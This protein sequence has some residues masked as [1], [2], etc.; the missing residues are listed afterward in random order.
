MERGRGRI[1]R[2]LLEQWGLVVTAAV[3]VLAYS[4]LVRLDLHFG[5]LRADI[6][7][8]TIGWY[9]LAFAA[10]LGAVIWTEKRPVSMRSVWTAAILFRLLLLFTS[11]SLSDDVYRYLWDGHIANQGVSPYA[12]AIN[13][14]ELDA[15]AI[16]LQE[17]ANN[18]EMASPYLPAAQWVFAG[19]TAV[20]PP[21][22]FILQL[23]M[24]VFDLIS[25][26]LIVR[27]LALAALPAHRALLYLWNPLVILETAHGAHI[28]A[29]MILLTLAAVKFTIDDRQFVPKISNLGMRI[30]GPLFMA[31]A[32]LTKVLPILLLPVLA[33]QWSWRQ[34]LA[35]VGFSI[36]IV[37]PAAWQ[38][39]WG[40][41]GEL[42]GTGLFG[43]LRI[44]AVQWNFNSGL[45]A[46]LEN[47][48]AGRGLGD[49]TSTAKWI[50]LALL[51][52]ILLGVWG[53]ARAPHSPRKTL[54]LAAI[55]FIA[56]LLL[57]PTVHPWYALIVLVL[58]PF[59][60]PGADEPRR[61]WLAVIPWL[62]LSGALVFSY[63]TYIDPLDFHEL[64]WVRGL[65]WGPTLAL[66]LVLLVIEVIQLISIRRRHDL[67]LLAWLQHILSDL[68]DRI[69]GR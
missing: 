56:Y 39:G 48:L 45:F 13:S 10:Y 31:L 52:I 41:T 12:Y 49:P 51:L 8:Q 23:S 28:D 44:Y 27:L 25:G 37:L 42:D 16:P 33:R 32:T 50:S 26:W 30:A 4:A 14:P 7:P 17:K 57:T 6:T 24:V 1:S 35:F 21:K 34:R 65:E 22:P 15:V 60:T 11:P 40:L 66:L 3:S 36:G 47:W 55:P 59:L 18:P 9:L 61:F 64:P 69:P 63:L 54:R 46:L 62:Y 43:A 58:T 5:T 38:S 67:N 29:W 2:T 20:F 53:L 68:A 19:L